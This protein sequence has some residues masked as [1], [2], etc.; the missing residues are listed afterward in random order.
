MVTELR[1]Y[2]EGDP[3]LR[4]GMSQ[5]LSEIWGAARKRRCKI[6]PVL[7][8]ANAVSDFCL[9]LQEHR[10]AWNIL[11]L[12]SEGPVD[13]GL[14]DQLRNSSGWQPPVGQENLEDKVF[15][16]VQLMEAWFLADVDTL[17]KYYGQGFLGNALLGNPRVE[18]IP[19]DD[20]LARLKQA[21]RHTKKGAYHKTRHAP[22]ILT[23]LNPDR[24]KQAS[25]N[26]KRLFDKVLARLG[27]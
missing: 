19:K 14:L 2:I 11:L 13:G 22:E 17:N 20:V 18:D 16:M 21:T 26:C 8:G 23:Q 15:W 5:F 3:R 6:R 10:D 24:V 7:C 25:P 4:P 1:I 12:D 9:A 27:E